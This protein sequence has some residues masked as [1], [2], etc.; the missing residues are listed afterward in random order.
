MAKHI[1]IWLIISLLAMVFIPLFLNGDSYAD[2]IR[3]DQHQLAID[4]GE[5]SASKIIRQSDGIYMKLFVE[6]GIQPFMFE[7]YSLDKKNLD[8]DLFKPSTADKGVELASKYVANLFLSLYDTI[9]R[10]TQLFYWFAFATPFIV[11]ATFDGLMQRKIRLANF[12]YSSPVIYNTMWH[13]LI[14][15]VSLTV[16]YCNSPFDMPS[17]VFPVIVF[18]VSISI[19]M[20]LANMQRSA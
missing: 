1:L 3:S 15:F 6:S 16:M 7:K 14:A 11:A 19:R 13:F 9:F 12:Q 5:E 17:S 20:L 8:P 18:V 10:F 4:L 2:K